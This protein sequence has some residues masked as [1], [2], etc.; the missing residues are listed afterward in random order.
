VH[1]AAAAQ[2]AV[3]AAVAAA[4]VAEPYTKLLEDFPDVVCPSG[5]LPPVKHSV[6]H[7]IETDGQPVVSKYRRLDPVK[8]A[9]A[10]KEFTQLEKQGIIRRSSSSWSSPLHMVQKADGSWRPCGDYRRLNLQ[11]K[12]DR[13]TCPNIGDLTARLAGCTI[14]S[15]LDLRKG[16]HQVPVRD[17]DVCKTAVITPFGT[18][19][20][21]RMPFGLCNA[22]QTFQRLMDSVLA[23]LPSC[24]VYMDDV[25]V[26]STSP[27]QYVAH[28]KEVLETQQQGLVLN[29]EKCSFGMS[30][31]DYLGHHISATGIRPMGARVE[32]I[33]KFP[34]PL[35]VGNLQTFLGMVNFYRR[36]MPT[37]AQV[38]RPL[39]DAVKGGQAA[40]VDWTPAMAAAFQRVKD[41][42]C[43]AVKLAHPEA[44]AEVF[45]AVDATG[46]HVGAVLQQRACGLVARPLAFFSSKLEPAQ[47]RYSAFDQELL[48]VYLAIRHFRWLLEGRTFYLLT[49]HKP[50]TFALHRV[51]D[52]WSSRQQ[53]QLTYIAEYTSDLRHMLG[54]S[55]MVADALSRPAAAIAMPAPARVDFAALAAAQA[56]Y[57]D[58]QKLAA[59]SSLQVEM[60]HVAG[61][62]MLCDTSTGVLRPMVP[63]SQRRAVFLAMHGLAHPGTRASRR[64][65]TSC[66]MW[67]GCSTD[68]GTWCRECTGCAKGMVTVHCQTAVEMIPVPVKKFS[69]VHMDIVGPLP[70]AACGKTYLL[71][72][73]DRT[74]RWPEAI[75]MTENTAERCADSFVEGWISR[76]GVHDVVTTDR[77]TQFTSTTWACLASKVGFEHVLTSAY[78]PQAN[79]MVERLHYQIKDALRA[80]ACGT[81]W[82]ENL[83]WVMLGLRAVPKDE[84]G[85]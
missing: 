12:P 5:E 26:A 71:T 6:L 57:E 82:V 23:G 10:Q 9:A 27:E 63:V 47:T 81:A 40:A 22:G 60:V 78:H 24:F 55:N 7:F 30:E 1:T 54:S 20:Y 48:A 83:P 2:G 79:G 66:F 80:R 76:F 56:T 36:F 37:A 11:T 4:R 73:I 49:D 8:I 45:L 32:A 50:L 43:S 21:L 69:H 77:G 68:V 18:Y 52:S 3:S 59:N 25:L 35:T 38:L 31:L 75:P 72:V 29:I 17:Q 70:T 39:T 67:R 62:R 65:I 19:E 46:T 13:Y 33:K 34:H 15:K 41:R 85:I 61:A 64:I 42:L 74:S 58:T 51:T 53:R 16:Y 84:S 14:F 44:N 28:L